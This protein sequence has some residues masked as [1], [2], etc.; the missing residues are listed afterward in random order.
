MN[1]NKVQDKKIWD[2]Q[3]I[4]QGFSTPDRSDL[5]IDYRINK[6]SRIL[7]L[8]CGYG[9]TLDK[10]WDL[11]YRN[12]VGI[13]YSDGMLNIARNQNSNISFHQGVIPDDIP[14]IEQVDF[15]FFLTVANCI[16]SDKVL[17][18]TFKWI[19]DVLKT[20]GMLIFDDY[21]YSHNP[22]YKERYIKAL[23]EFDHLGL[24]RSNHGEIFKHRTR[25]T[26]DHLLSSFFE[27]EKVEI[28]QEKSMNNRNTTIIHYI[29]RRING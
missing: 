7:D 4:N 6:E 10:C 17:F 20:N 28:S 15:V 24:F 27:F 25:D 23:D 29:L 13:D 14:C 2:E 22:I 3:S 12:L 19:H 11:G 21:I 1:F 16:I 26:F 8:G 5:L 9:R 18:R